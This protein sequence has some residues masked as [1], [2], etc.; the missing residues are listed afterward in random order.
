MDYRGQEEYLENLIHMH[1]YTHEDV[2]V[3]MCTF[4]KPKKPLDLRTISSFITCSS[5]VTTKSR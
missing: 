3:R 5:L 1:I 2:Y 4:A